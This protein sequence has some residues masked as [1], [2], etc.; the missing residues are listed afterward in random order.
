MG[1][2]PLSA[3]LASVSA[4]SRAS[5]SPRAVHSRDPAIVSAQPTADTAVPPLLGTATPSES[6]G[7]TPRHPA[8][9]ATS[10]SARTDSRIPI[11]ENIS[12]TNSGVNAVMTTPVAGVNANAGLDW[13]SRPSCYS[14]AAVQRTIGHKCASR[15]TTGVAAAALL[16][17]CLPSSD[18]DV[19]VSRASPKGVT[20][21]RP[22]LS[23]Q[24]RLGDV[25]C[26]TSALPGTRYAHQ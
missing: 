5:S 9:V 26:A 11:A 15:G 4:L 3:G 14:N 22:A 10:N 20:A 13:T 16:I 24:I 18:R 17:G 2:S 23:C 8:V 21:L 12:S 1:D 6:P 25:V 7:A 19:L